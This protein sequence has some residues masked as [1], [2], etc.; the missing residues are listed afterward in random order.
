MS[1]I[2]GNISM[3]ALSKLVEL[4]DKHSVGTLEKKG[5]GC[6]WFCPVESESNNFSNKYMINNM[7]Y[8]QSL[9]ID[10]VLIWLTRSLVAF[11]STDKYKL[12]CT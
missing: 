6:V 11:H 5:V 12:L 10:S 7:G 4:Y 1:L 8:I 3:K 9:R 2:F